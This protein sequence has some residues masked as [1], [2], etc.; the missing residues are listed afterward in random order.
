MKAIMVLLGLL[1]GA[2]QLFSGQIM[3]P[4]HHQSE[5]PEVLSFAGGDVVN[6]SGHPV[7]PPG[8]PDLPGK[9]LRF[10]IPLTA[11][12]VSV[13]MTDQEWVSLGIFSIFPRQP[14]VP[15]GINPLP[16]IK[17]NTIY[18][19]NNFYPADPVTSFNTGNK[20]GFQIAGVVYTPFR[21]NPVTGELQF[22]MKASLVIDYAEGLSYPV[23]LTEGQIEVYSWDVAGLVLNAQEVGFNAPLEKE[24]RDGDIEYVIV[25][26]EELAQY[27]EPLVRWKNQKGIPAKVF[28]AQWIYSHYQG[29]DNMERI[30]NFVRDYHQ[31]HGLIY[32]VL[33]GD[34]DNLGARFIH[35]EVAFFQISTDMPSDLYFSDIVP[36]EK[37]WDANG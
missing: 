27:F 5:F 4:V 8:A 6:Y 19:Q 24:S 21:Y 34:Q 12:V 1:L 3:W 36:Y 10:S 29:Y 25:A 16:T 2:L 11:S 23:F 14:D 17:N 31:N 35:S 7:C 32:L 15:I 9:V 18:G 37:N 28:S 30:R 26:P 20:S 13:E 22:L 33:A